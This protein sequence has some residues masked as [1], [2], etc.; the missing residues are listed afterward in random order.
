ML[1]I[2][3]SHSPQEIIALSDKKFSRNFDHVP[4][5]RL[6]DPEF[7]RALTQ[8]TIELPPPDSGRTEMVVHE[9][10]ASIFSAEAPKHTLE[11]L[12]RSVFL[13]SA[14]ADFKNTLW[15]TQ[16]KDKNKIRGLHYYWSPERFNN[17]ALVTQF[18]PDLKNTVDYIWFGGAGNYRPHAIWEMPNPL[19][20]HAEDVSLPNADAGS[21]HLPLIVDFAFHKK[22]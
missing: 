12:S 16:G 15:R 8:I 7:L 1:E 11:L 4:E 5:K 18:A 9:N 21:D 3:A 14:Y 22:G 2:L 10:V 13:K 20:L 17:D 6:I 19:T